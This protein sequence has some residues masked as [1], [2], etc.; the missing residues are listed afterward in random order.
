MRPRLGVV[1]CTRANGEPNVRPFDHSSWSAR[2]GG[3]KRNRAATKADNV[4][5]HVDMASTLNHD[6][7]DDLMEAMRKFHERCGQASLLLFFLVAET[8]L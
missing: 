5:G 4:N 7:L 6:H 3:K 1:Q 2:G 8:E